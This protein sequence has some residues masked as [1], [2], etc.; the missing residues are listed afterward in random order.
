MK[1]KL[2]QKTRMILAFVI[3]CV[4][5]FGMLFTGP[6][7]KFIWQVIITSLMMFFLFWLVT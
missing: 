5:T 4:V 7:F 6:G 1:S 2:S 3:L